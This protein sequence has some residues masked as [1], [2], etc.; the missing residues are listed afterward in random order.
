VPLAWTSG[1]ERLLSPP[2]NKGF[3][4][5]AQKSNRPFLLRDDPL[6]YKDSI[7]YEVHVRA[8][9][10]SNAD[11]I[12]DLR[13]LL[14]KLDYLQDLGVTVL[15]LLPFYPSPL[16]DDGYDIADYTD[17]NSIYGNLDDFKLLMRE[18]HRRGLRVITELVIN[19]TSDQHPW[20]QRARYA[21]PGTTWRDFYVWSDTADKYPDARI[22]FEIESSNWT[23]DPVA[24]AYYWHRFY[25]HQPDLNFDNPAVHEAVFEV[26]DFWLNL[27]VD[28]MRLDAVPFLYE[29]EGTTCESLPETHDFL[30]RLRRH[31]DERYRNRMLLAEANH[32][33]EEMVPYF[34]TGDECH[35]AFHFPLMPRLFMAIR[36]EERFPIIDILQQTPAIPEN[37][38]WA[39]FLRNHD[40]MTLAMITDEDRDYMFRMYAQDTHARVHLGIRRR[41]APLLEN[42]RGKIELMN[43]LLFSLPGTPVLYYGDEIGMG[44]NIYLGDRNGVRTPMQWN[45]ERNAGF[46]RTNPQRLYLPVIIDPEYHY[47]T[48]NVEAQ[49]NNSHSLLWWMKRLI[50]LRKRFHVFGRG[51]LEFLYPENHKVLV[52]LR[53]HNAERILVVANLSRFVQ[54]VELNLEAFKG[55]VPIEMFG[56]TPMP[57]VGDRP[58]LLTVGPYAFYWLFL[59]PAHAT[60]PLA[61]APQDG[62]DELEVTGAWQDIFQKRTAENLELILLSYLRRQRWFANKGG[63]SKSARIIEQ[64]PISHDGLMV[65]IALIQ[66][67]YAEGE[68]RTFVLPITFAAT[69]SAEE[70]QGNPPR[71]VICRLIVHGEAGIEPSRAREEAGIL[72]DPLGEKDFSAELLEA[73]ARHQTFQGTR[74]DL[75]AWTTSPFDRLREISDPRPEPALV[76][77]DQSNTSVAYGNRLILK[78]LRCVEEGVNLEVEI[79]RALAEK[80]SFAHAAPL[81]G[82]LEYRR[83]QGQPMALAVLSGFV[84]NEGDAWHYTLDSLQRFFE[85]VLTHQVPGQGPLVPNRPFLD[86]AAEDL[87][88]MAA[89]QIGSYL[90]AVRLMGRRT[91]EMHVAFAS[92]T[93]DP[94]FSPEAFTPLYQMSM[95]QSVRS[96]VYRI[97]NLLRDHIKLI[98]DEARASAQLV[99]G[100]EADFIQHMRTIISRPVAAQRIRGHGDY[101]LGSLLYT[102]KD[103]VVIDFEGEVLRPLSDR[104]HKRS[105]LRDVASMLHSL[106]SAVRTASTEDH[107]RP[108]DKLV[109]QPWA[110]FWETWVSVAFV[111]AYLE[112]AGTGSFLP[113]N[114]E[115]MQLLL[116]FHVL[117]RGIVEL[118][119][120]LLNR[121]DRVQI[122]LR[123]LLHL[124]DLRDRRLGTLSEPEA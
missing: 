47:Q 122:P 24:K 56:W 27:D 65:S 57:A 32:W 117:G 22:M 58:Y 9:C 54:C 63:L 92:I 100:R 98:P 21:A 53:R 85:Y 96:G 29:R 51:T 108:E 94:A 107:L 10:D 121:P 82:A 5:K 55:M 74:G 110:L 112:I 73:F 75:Q 79:G 36:M 88:P 7:I 48:V 90:E 115:D 41:L 20:F 119:Y 33:P 34:G 35:M 91:A 87:P 60:K 11:G 72:Y 12:G 89:E 97:F 8:F 46:S 26:L 101:R 14:E 84:P 62:P 61:P 116:D 70:S 114:R 31:V 93:K 113:R 43:G 104:R 118:Q 86:L 15:W 50:A 66:V 78:F 124:I 111:K 30:R 49:Q 45:P 42:H 103:F 81:A 67:E 99:L 68:P 17:V 38:Q 71:A 64:I 19:H 25:S 40:E 102:G 37:A 39:L 44:D 2:V 3:M 28:G 59:E 120:Q 77:A 16:R 18:A 80:T 1:S 69:P 52:F 13:G 83:G 123:T 23:W 106:S 4:M 95:Y 105:S 76:K 109:V 6:W